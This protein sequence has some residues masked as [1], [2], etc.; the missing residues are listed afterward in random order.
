MFPA[1]TDSSSKRNLWSPWLQGL[2]GIYHHR[3]KENLECIPP[4]PSS[5]IHV[6]QCGFRIRCGSNGPPAPSNTQLSSVPGGKSQRGTVPRD[7]VAGTAPQHLFPWQRE[8]WPAKTVSSQ[9]VLCYGKVE[10]SVGLKISQESICCP[11]QSF[12][13]HQQ[14]EKQQGRGK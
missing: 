3:E 5:A 1:G 2:S 10:V 11:H 8:R 4:L 9:T 14:K 7:S 13:P 12:A 6:Y